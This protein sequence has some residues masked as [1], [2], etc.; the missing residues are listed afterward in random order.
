MIKI[1]VQCHRLPEYVAQ[2][3]E[4][5]DTDQSAYQIRVSSSPVMDHRQD[6]V[7]TRDRV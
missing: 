6:I 2:K 1:K 3:E 4:E 5:T 7:D